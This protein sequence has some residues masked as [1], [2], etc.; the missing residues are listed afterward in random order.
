MYS[1]GF[2][3][4]EDYKYANSTV[5]FLLKIK[6]FWQQQENNPSLFDASIGPYSWNN[7]VDDEK[8]LSASP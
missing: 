8:Q 6:Y 2:F 1:P 4:A 7:I 3:D 5:K